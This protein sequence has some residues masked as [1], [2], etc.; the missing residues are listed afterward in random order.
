MSLSRIS[1]HGEMRNNFRVF[2]TII[3]T[4]VN[5]EPRE[6]TMGTQCPIC[7]LFHNISD[8]NYIHKAQNILRIVTSCKLKI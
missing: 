1:G 6:K 8:E 7:L 2:H 5:V 4:R 3:E